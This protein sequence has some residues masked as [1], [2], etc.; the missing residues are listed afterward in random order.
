M[1]R[2]SKELKNSRSNLGDGIDSDVVNLAYAAFPEDANSVMKIYQFIEECDLMWSEVGREFY[3]KD[4][5]SPQRTLHA[6][7]GLRRQNISPKDYLL[8]FK[9]WERKIAGT[10]NSGDA[11]ADWAVRGNFLLSLIRNR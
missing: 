5:P 1:A 2:L 6:E 11:Q 8:T 3:N 10:A 4:L 9:E 7:V